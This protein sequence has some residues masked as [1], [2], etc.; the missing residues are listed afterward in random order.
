MFLQPSGYSASVQNLAN[1]SL[2]QD[3][4][5]SDGYGTQMATVSGDT[6]NGYTARLTV[7]VDI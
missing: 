2:E 5:F 1:V 4:V 3:N 7:G 6:T